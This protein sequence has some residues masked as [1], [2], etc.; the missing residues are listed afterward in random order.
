MATTN[1]QKGD[2]RMF[3]QAQYLDVDALGVLPAFLLILVM[4]LTAL[5]VVANVAFG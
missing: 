4:L 1:D 3:A 2:A 5:G